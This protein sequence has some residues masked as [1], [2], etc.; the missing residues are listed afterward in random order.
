[1]LLSLNGHSA[2]CACT[3]P[4]PVEG[5]FA[6]DAFFTSPLTLKKLKPSIEK[7][8]VFVLTG[9]NEQ[10]PHWVSHFIV[11]TANEL[12]VR[13]R[14]NEGV[15]GF[16]LATCYTDIKPVLK[17]IQSGITEVIVG[18]NPLAPEHLYRTIMDLTS[19]RLAH[20]KSSCRVSYK[21]LGFYPSVRTASP[22]PRRTI[23]DATDRGEGR[24]SSL[25]ESAQ[26]CFAEHIEAHSRIDLSTWTLNRGRHSG[27]MDLSIIFFF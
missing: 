19:K 1:M 2:Y 11:P 12:L 6:P 23:P 17:V 25:R 21:M 10:C 9:P 7:I 8:E 20:E 16:G 18:Q 26:N 13:L 5:L 27:V 15:E 4:I 24:A 3:R 22:L 14:T